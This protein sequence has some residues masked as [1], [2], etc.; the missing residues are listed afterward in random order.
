MSQQKRVQFVHLR[1]RVNGVAADRGGYT[2]AVKERADGMFAITICQ[3]NN[4]QRYDEKLG[5]KIAEMRMGRGQF[6]VQSHDELVASLGT[7]HNKLCSGAVPKLNLD[8][9]KNEAVAA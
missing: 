3:C 1:S 4:N 7:L 2:V 8:V 5:E 6:F 9:L